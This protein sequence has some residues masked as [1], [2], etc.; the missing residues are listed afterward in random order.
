MALHPSGVQSHSP[1]Q[2]TNKKAEREKRDRTLFL[3]RTF[4]IQRERELL[5]K[6]P[7][8]LLHTIG[9]SNAAKNS[10]TLV[11]DD[12]FIAFEGTVDGLACVAR[13]VV[14]LGLN[15]FLPSSSWIV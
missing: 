8:L 1:E 6:N 4:S 9:D 11:N 5:G 12:A 3:F 10:S 15:A 7:S 2:N 14:L 13:V